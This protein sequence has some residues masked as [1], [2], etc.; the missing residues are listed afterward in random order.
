MKKEILYNKHMKVFAYGSEDE[1]D[2]FL[3]WFRSKEELED[4]AIYI[5]NNSYTCTF[6]AKG[7]DFF[8]LFQALLFNRYMYKFGLLTGQ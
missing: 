3:Y 8:G 1:L 2:G 5:L 4:I 6:K 7:V